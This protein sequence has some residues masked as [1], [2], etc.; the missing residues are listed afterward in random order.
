[1]HDV[2]HPRRARGRPAADRVAAALQPPRERRRREVAASSTRPRRH[3]SSSP[4]T[5]CARHGSAPSAYAS[6]SASRPSTT[7]SGTSSRRSPPPSERRRVRPVT[8]GD[9]RSSPR[10]SARR[11]SREPDVSEVGERNPLGL[12]QGRALPNPDPVPDDRH[13]RAEHELLQRERVRGDLPRRERL[14]HRARQPRPRGR[15]RSSAGRSTRT[16]RPPR[17]AILA[18]SRSSTSSGPPT[19]RPEIAEQ[20]VAIGAR[21][22]WLQ[23]GVISEPAAEIARAAGLDVVMDRCCKIEHARMFG[24]CARSGST[25]GSSP[26]ASRCACRK[27]ERR[28]RARSRSWHRARRRIAA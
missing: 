20:A 2:R 13:G 25:P 7:S 6:R 5:S 17:K 15:R 22:L 4:T 18:R 1:M 9:T 10:R 3:T 14:R 24:V 19:R 12:T 11:T 23:L 28:P 26:A 16:W 27:A 21:V 8:A